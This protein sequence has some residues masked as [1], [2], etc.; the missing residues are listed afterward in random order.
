LQ[1]HTVGVFTNDEHLDDFVDTFLL[2]VVAQSIVRLE[3]TN[4]DL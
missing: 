3:G 1:V 4:S 2:Q